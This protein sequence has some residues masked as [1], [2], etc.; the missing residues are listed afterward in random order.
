MD[1]DLHDYTCSAHQISQVGTL[2]SHKPPVL[3]DRPYPLVATLEQ[4]LPHVVLQL[5]PLLQHKPGQTV[6]AE[7]THVLSRH[8]LQDVEVAHA[9]DVVEGLQRFRGCPVD[10]WGEGVD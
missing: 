7:G 6:H 8:S 4:T 9:G 3:P 2:S 10:V 5:V 1:V